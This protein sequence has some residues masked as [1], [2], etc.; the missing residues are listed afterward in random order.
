VLLPGSGSDD[1]FV[2]RAF[3]RPLAALGITL[4]AVAPPGDGDPAA[5]YRAALDATADDRALVGG[6][7]LGAQVAA[8]WAAGRTGPSRPAGLLLA[9]P[10]WRGRPD[11]APAA[12]SARL[13]A[14]LLRREG[15]PGALAAARAGGTPGWL[16]A[17]LARAWAGY[18][19]G[20]AGALD[21]TAATPGPT[22]AELAALD[23]PTGVA[24]LHDDPVHPHTEAVAWVR[25][26]P[27]AAL[28]TTGFAA[29]GA[30]PEALGRAAVLAW[31]RALTGSAGP[32][33][34]P[35]GVG[36]VDADR[37]EQPGG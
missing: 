18:G 32:V 13:T 15:L 24:A 36:G 37:R 28:R 10:A 27:V 33:V 21:A 23:I 14:D 3:A 35:G 16:V 34:A 2:R 6:I 11:T 8:A 29:F 25:A 5:G 20:L 31:L 17:E 26:L 9:L 12:L 22:D 1:V 30:D 7:S 4:E 19:P